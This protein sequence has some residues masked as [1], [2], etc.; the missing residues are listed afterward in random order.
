MLKFWRRDSRTKSAN[1]SS[2]GDRS[3]YAIGDIHGRHDLLQILIDLVRKDV[4]ARALPNPP[5]LVFLGD[6]VDRGRYS[7]EVVDCVLDLQRDFSVVALRGNHEDAL[8]Q[9]LEDPA[10]GPSWIDH[11]GA[12][13][14]VSYGVNPPHRADPTPWQDVRDSFAEALPPHHLAFF[15]G[16][17][18]H[19]VIG[20][21]VFAHAGVRPGVALED[22]T[23]HDFMWIRRPFLN[24]ER[25]I[26]RVVVHGHTPAETPHM[27]RWRIGV[28]TG[29]YA[30]GVLT[31][32]GL[33]GSER[34]FLSARQGGGP[35]P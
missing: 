1:A 13:T 8:L 22:Q 35:T 7:R 11:G 28:D 15:R 34:F 33:T 20:D 2:I 9:F 30:T 21:Y 19:A 25:A 14:L 4:A 10:I 31:A 24:V 17:A 5:F 32:I 29:A 23:A 26:D 16:L 12:Q 18:Y 6:Y 3:A 27:G